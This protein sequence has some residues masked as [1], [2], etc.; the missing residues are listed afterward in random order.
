[1]IG[2]F[3]VYAHAKPCG[4]IFYVGK[5]SKKR[6]WSK[7]DRNNHWKNIVNKYGYNVIILSDNLEEEDSLKL[8]I[9]IIAH[10]VKFK[11]L[12]NRTLGGDGA[13]GL[14]HND[15]FKKK[16]SDY[17]KSELNP[18]KRKDVA[19]KLGLSISG[20]NHP[21]KKEGYINKISGSKNGMYGRSGALSPTSK[22]ITFNGINFCSIKEAA[23]YYGMKYLNFYNMFNKASKK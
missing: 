4:E 20:D 22:P 21:T 15:E 1:M 3:Y 12:C 2:N 16:R 9:E 7:K 17:M 13:K 11:K 8:E 10:F 14:Q 23:D 5:G 18:M 19:R 6:A